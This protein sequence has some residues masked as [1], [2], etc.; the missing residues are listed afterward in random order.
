M[1]TGE[2]AVPIGSA[3]VAEAEETAFVATA[4]R[5][6]VA[7]VLLLIPIKIVLSGYRPVFDDPLADAAKA[8]SG[9][10]W[11]DVLVLKEQFRMDPHVG[12]HAVL[13]TLA[14]VAQWSTS[15]VVIFAV[16]ALFALL[17]LSAVPWLERPEAWLATFVVVVGAGT[18]AMERYMLGRP[19]LIS[20]AVLTSILWLWNTHGAEPPTKRRIA[21]L[22][23]LFAIAAL[24]H[25]S[26]YLWS[27]LVLSF[28][29]AGEYQWARTIGAT[30]IAGTIIGA[31]LTGQPLGYL[32]ES[33]RMG[34]DAFGQH[35]Y[36]STLVHEF[37]PI[38]DNMP[39][40]LL[41]AGLII[42]RRLGDFETPP[43]RKNPAF[44][45]GCIGLALGY[46]AMRFW[47]DWGLIALMV[48]I[49]ADIERFMKSRVSI[50]ALTRVGLAFGLAGTLYLMTTNDADNR[51]TSSRETRYLSQD[52]P[53]LAGWLPQS[54][55]VLY[56]TE[57]GLFYQTFYKNPY[58]P[59]RYITGFEPAMMPDDDFVT[60]QSIGLSHGNP[61][62]YMP[63]VKKMRPED[64]IAMH[65]GEQPR[66]A[67]L[68]WKNVNGVWLGRPPTHPQP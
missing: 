5:W 14:H 9:R 31:C 67:A 50:Y 55:G 38:A 10:D 37:R 27:L 60:F 18:G 54:G 39:G 49:A 33:V 56:T 44:W 24:L 19:F 52:D 21:I 59:W 26:W 29:I 66:I 17:A 28:V 4:V 68:E 23:G 22:T 58:A 6:I 53:Q 51:W 40:L 11:N 41:V 64:R 13:Q 2:H 25:G 61:A 36:Q 35:A 48:A 47:G 32:V 57:M 34:F 12:W 3:E 62:A 30:W 45:L 15:D 1:R 8:I 43:L 63:W 46:K 20:A 16:V 42:F 7:A 65:W